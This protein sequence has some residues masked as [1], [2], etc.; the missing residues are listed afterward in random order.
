MEKGSL[1]KLWTPLDTITA[2]IQEGGKLLD[3]YCSIADKGCNQNP[4][5][6]IMG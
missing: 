2:N 5:I 6:I 1:L 3:K 4:L